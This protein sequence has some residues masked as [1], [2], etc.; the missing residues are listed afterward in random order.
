MRGFRCLRSIKTI[1]ETNFTSVCFVLFGVADGLRCMEFWIRLAISMAVSKSMVA[2]EEQQHEFVGEEGCFE[3]MLRV[4]VVVA[5]V[6]DGWI[7]IEKVKYGSKS[8]EPVKNRD[9][10]HGSDPNPICSM[11]VELSTHKSPA[12]VRKPG[13]CRFSS[14]RPVVENLPLWSQSSRPGEA[15]RSIG[16]GVAGCSWLSR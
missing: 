13:N 15:G 5:I 7:R 8:L 16:L 2:N 10:L 6:R 4:D 12:I 14:A 9:H 11:F 1:I 3:F